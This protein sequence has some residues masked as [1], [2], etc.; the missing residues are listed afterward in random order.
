MLERVVEDG[1]AV[2]PG[3]VIADVVCR[4][5]VGRYGEIPS[6]ASIW[7]KTSAVSRPRVERMWVG[8]LLIGPKIV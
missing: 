5:G 3:A 8:S 4:G 6:V 2:L 1:T 7:S